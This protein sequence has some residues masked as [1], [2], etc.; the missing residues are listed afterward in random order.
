[1]FGLGGRRKAP[2]FS[3]S[4]PSAAPTTLPPPPARPDWPRQVGI[5][6]DTLHLKMSL[7]DR[8]LLWLAQGFGSGRLRPGPGTW[9]SLVGCAWA[10]LLLHVPSGWALVATIAAILAAVPVCSR[11]ES[12]LGSPD[13]GSV[14]LDEIVAMPL[15]LLPLRAAGQLGWIPALDLSRASAGLW[16][17][18][19]FVLFRV[20]DIAKPWPVGALQ[21][22]PRG[23][24][25]VLDDV[26]AGLI[27]GILLLA[28][29]RILT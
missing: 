28:A 25:I 4:S 2:A 16:W 3:V 19:A 5:P 9:G 17:L 12:L 21:N 14:V 13:P 8:G 1:M 18:G 15:V 29:A 10:G 11:A 6:E 20:L 27:G 22:L 24:G 26:A 23:W 7:S